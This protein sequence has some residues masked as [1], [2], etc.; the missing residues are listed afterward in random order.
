M[1]SNYGKGLTSPKIEIRDGQNRPA[2]PRAAAHAYAT[3]VRALQSA[4]LQHPD[5]RV[6]LRHL[7]VEQKETEL[8][9][10]RMRE[11]WRGEARG[12]FVHL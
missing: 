9:E 10:A 8:C 7:L 1:E 6:M 5:M 2:L 4:S 12:D 11:Q 3:L